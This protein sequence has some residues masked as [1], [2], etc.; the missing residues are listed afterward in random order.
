[1]KRAELLAQAIDAGFTEA[2]FKALTVPQRIAFLQAAAW[3]KG[4]D[5]QTRMLE[6]GAETQRIHRKRL[7]IGG[8]APLPGEVA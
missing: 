3:A 7:I 1:M 5:T 2:Q 4:A 8:A 6:V